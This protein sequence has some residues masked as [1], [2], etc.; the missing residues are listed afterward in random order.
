M[1]ETLAPRTRICVAA[2]LTLDTQTIECRIASRW[3]TDDADRFNRRPA[4]F[5]LQA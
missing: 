4:I 3:R 1:A 2:D 5:L